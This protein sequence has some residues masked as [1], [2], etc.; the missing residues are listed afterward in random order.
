MVRRVK[1]TGARGRWVAEVE[2]RMLAVLHST[3]MQPGGQLFAPFDDGDPR[4][5]ARYEEFQEA[6]RNHE[7]VVIQ[8]DRSA[9]DFTRNGYVGVFR[10]SDLE[11]D[12]A[13]GISLRLTER[14]A[15]PA[16]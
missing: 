3:H 8:R 6:L 13:S 15:D 11:I 12:Y 7:L 2:G 1:I 14:Y 4:G 10:F 9:T 16:P 5:R